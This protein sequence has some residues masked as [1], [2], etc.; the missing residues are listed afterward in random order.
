MP[1][2]YSFHKISSKSPPVSLHTIFFERKHKYEV[3]PWG[4][5]KS[6]AWESPQCHAVCPTCH[7]M[8]TKERALWS[9]R[10]L[11]PVC[12]RRPWIER[13]AAVKKSVSLP[14]RFGEAHNSCLMPQLFHTTEL[15]KRF[16]YIRIRTITKAIKKSHNHKH[17]N[18]E[19]I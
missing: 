19:P 2:R 8:A 4:K 1:R 5:R 9:F 11:L 10:S 12:T 14:A 15:N 13:A 6:W 17:M 7:T 3:M 16:V 18:D